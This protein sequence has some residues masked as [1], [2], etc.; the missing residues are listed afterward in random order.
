LS[1]FVEFFLKKSEEFFRFFII[2]FLEQL[3]LSVLEITLWF[4]PAE[5]LKTVSFYQNFS[6][7]LLVNRRRVFF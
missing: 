2:C 3:F 1:K 5:R 4:K 6:V 7:W